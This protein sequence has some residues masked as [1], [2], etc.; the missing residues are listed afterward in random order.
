M[1]R[2]N[3]TDLPDNP[4]LPEYNFDDGEDRIVGNAV[5]HIKEYVEEYLHSPEPGGMVTIDDLLGDIKL[6]LE[7]CYD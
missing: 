6:W 2:T 7:E 5:L 3:L 1:S 4:R